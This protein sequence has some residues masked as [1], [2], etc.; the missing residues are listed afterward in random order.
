MGFILLGGVEF[1]LERFSVLFRLVFLRMELNSFDGIGEV[2]TLGFA[3]DFGVGI[4]FL[5]GEGFP[6]GRLFDFFDSDSIQNF[7]LF[8]DS[9]LL[10]INLRVLF[11]TGVEISYEVLWWNW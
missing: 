11:G 7:L 8:S 1:C 2:F 5:V 9:G 10:R 6:V 3:G 4:E